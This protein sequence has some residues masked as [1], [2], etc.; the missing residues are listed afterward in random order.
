MAEPRDTK[1]EALQHFTAANPGPEPPNPKPP[2][3][4]PNTKP[5]TPNPKPQTPNPNPQTPNSKPRTPNPK[6]QTLKQVSVADLFW[7]FRVPKVVDYLSLDIE[8]AE[9]YCFKDFL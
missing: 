5:Q 9:Y 2:T 3:P 6:P 1:M 7:Q 4:T 8:G